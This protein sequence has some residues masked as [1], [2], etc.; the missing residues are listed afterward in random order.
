MTVSYA[1]GSALGMLW[2][3][4]GL[5]GFV[6][7]LR[8]LQARLPVL[9]RPWPQGVLFAAALAL[10][11]GLLLRVPHL[12]GVREFALVVPFLGLLAGSEGAIAGAV[13]MALALPAF[14]LISLAGGV[15]TWVLTRTRFSPLLALPVAWMV[16]VLQ[17]E[18]PRALVG[19]GAPAG[20]LGVA[21][22]VLGALAFYVYVQ[23][24]DLRRRTLVQAQRRS[25][26]DPLTGLLNRRGLDEWLHERRGGEIAAVMLDLDDFKPVNE[27]YGHD[28]GD[29][30]LLQAAARLAACVRPE[31]ALAR[32]GGDEFVAV[33][34]GGD[35][36]TA[37]RVAG[38][39]QAR[40]AEEDMPVAGTTLHVSAS[41]G[42]AQGKGPSCL[43]QADAALLQAKAQG[44]SDIEVF[45]DLA[46]GGGEA[47]S[48][49]RVTRFAR[50][51]MFRLPLGVVV[52]DRGRRILAA[53]SGYQQLSG[54]GG[55]HLQGRN[56][57]QVVGTDV[58]DAAVFRDVG[59]TL[60]AKGMWHGEFVDRRPG[61]EL[62]WAE[63]ALAPIEVRGHHLGYIGVLQ[64]ATPCHAREAE[65]LVAAI[66][67]LEEEHDRTIRPHLARS[68][69][70]M[71]LAVEAWHE[72]Y[73]REALPYNPEQYAR[74]SMLHDV[75]KLSVRPSILAKPG[76]LTPEERVAIN[77]HP[78]E[79]ARLITR[80]EDLLGPGPRSEY[81]R[82]FLDLAHAF[83]LHHHE[84]L[85]GTGYPHG[86]KGL[87]IPLAV[88]IFT[89][90]DVYDALQ[91]TRPYKTAWPE[92]EAFHY[93]Q[94]HA[95]TLFDP[96]AVRLVAQLRE[97]DAWH[98]VRTADGVGGAA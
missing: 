73:G 7:L 51:M 3:V 85:D 46:D 43:A 29:Q 76:P 75:G 8:F 9:G 44:R 20:A 66:A 18:A 91:D 1:L 94:A 6:E 37:L 58:T 72:A 70:Y 12:A 26:S 15:A 61:G 38:R 16:M 11:S 88:R 98:A 10:A 93:L 67:L 82:I 62:W 2:F 65:M 78:E 92:A 80:L 79:G 74:A 90:L 39:M 89:V 54:F 84:S 36:E 41:F 27:I 81:V 23:E 57:R 17:G 59:R 40:L 97:H 77:R 96:E 49:L 83:A 47:G 35:V 56:P 50:E 86:L 60:D 42:I 24:V 14:A 55:E 30:V 87:D 68:G 69:A 71:R 95:G 22:S 31:D 5:I 19:A 13:A 32:V 33:L 48:V 64:D 28:G 52:T 34:P 63:A 4:S 25:A 45:D 21:V 53:S